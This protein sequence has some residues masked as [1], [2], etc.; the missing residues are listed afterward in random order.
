VV[1]AAKMRIEFWIN[2]IVII[3]VAK[4]QPIY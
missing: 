3:E 2:Y 1:E 4:I